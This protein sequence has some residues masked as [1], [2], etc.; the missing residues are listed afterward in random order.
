MTLIVLGA[1]EQTGWMWKDH[2]KLEEIITLGCLNELTCP[3]WKPFK[4][5]EEMVAKRRE[6]CM[7]WSCIC[8]YWSW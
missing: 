8:I 6:T 3:G 7:K 2:D 5:R 4:K 1:L